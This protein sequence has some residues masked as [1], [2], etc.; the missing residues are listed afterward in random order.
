MPLTFVAMENELLTGKK[1]IRVLKVSCTRARCNALFFLTAVATHFSFDGIQL[2][3]FSLIK[4]G[5]CTRV[6]K[7]RLSATRVG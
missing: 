5:E 2:G 6:Y 3:R 1:A 7:T 4:E